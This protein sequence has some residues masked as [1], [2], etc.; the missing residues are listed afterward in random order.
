MTESD[1]EVKRNN[2][3]KIN[4]LRILIANILI[5]KEFIQ[6]VILRFLCWQEVG[7]KYPPRLPLFKQI[8]VSH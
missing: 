8:F 4:D 3:K 5:Y 6:S 2:S 7:G 1:Q